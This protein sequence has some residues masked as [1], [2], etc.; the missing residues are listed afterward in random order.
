[1]YRIILRIKDY[2]MKRKVLTKHQAMHAVQNGELPDT[3]IKAEKDVVVVMT[4][5]WCPQW[6]NLRNWMD[7]AADKHGL[8]VFELEY[9]TVDFFN[10]FLSFKERTWQNDQVPYLRYYRNGVCYEETNAV[11]EQQFHSIIKKGPKAQ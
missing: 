9:N 2:V 5:D 4:Q 7:A 3:V 11:S 6:S 1:V 8:A 10:E